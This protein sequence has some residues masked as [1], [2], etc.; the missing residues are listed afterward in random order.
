MEI[1]VEAD[2]KKVKQFID[3]L[4]SLDYAEV[5]DLKERI[6]KNL[7]ECGKVGIFL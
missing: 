5:K 3:L 6:L 4:K 1:V 2:N 7:R